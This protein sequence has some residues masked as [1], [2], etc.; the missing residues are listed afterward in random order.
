MEHDADVMPAAGTRLSCVIL[1]LSANLTFLPGEAVPFPVDDERIAW[2]LKQA[3]AREDRYLLAVPRRDVSPGDPGMPYEDV[4]TLVTYQLMKL[5]SGE[6]KVMLEGVGR[7]RLL[8]LADIQN[9][10]ECEAE[11]VPDTLANEGHAEDFALR[12]S[13]LSD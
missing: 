10:L 12:T 1:P 2:T 3:I 11:I 13:S 9:S 8:K 5:P 4:G 6:E 7:A